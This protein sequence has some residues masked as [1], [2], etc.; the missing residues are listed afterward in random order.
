MFSARIRSLRT[1]N[2]SQ[3][4]SSHSVVFSFR[5][6]ISEED[7]P[8]WR[9]RAAAAFHES[10]ERYLHHLLQRFNN[11]NSR[12]L[13]VGQGNIFRSTWI[14]RKYKPGDG[15]ATPGPGWPTSAP[16]QMLIKGLTDDHKRL[17]WNLKLKA[18][19]DNGFA[20]EIT[21]PKTCVYPTFEVEKRNV[22]SVRRLYN[23]FKATLFQYWLFAAKNFSN[24]RH[25]V[26][27]PENRK[28]LR[29]SKEV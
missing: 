11:L 6:S 21:T 14:I 16:G 2:G 19:Q 13:N 28:R 5:Y 4:G 22:K 15:F 7:Y 26:M 27:T 17:L 18:C 1:S 25:W 23:Y 12:L 24:R 9:Y 20:R 10:L 29:L 3:L 8:L